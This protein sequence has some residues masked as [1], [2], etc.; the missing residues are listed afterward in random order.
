MCN[1]HM[2][3]VPVQRVAIIPTSNSPPT[4]E[5]SK[6]EWYVLFLDAL[7]AR[8][9]LT[10]A[11][12]VLLVTCFEARKVTLPCPECRGHYASDWETW[13]FTAAHARSAEAATAW[14]QALKDRVDARV[15]AEKK[16]EAAAAAATARAQRVTT[17]PAPRLSLIHI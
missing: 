6:P 14:V 2:S 17:A 8:P 15:A 7:Q 1:P 10:D 3:K 9:D 12:V 13:P 4:W 5:W 16:A 11:E